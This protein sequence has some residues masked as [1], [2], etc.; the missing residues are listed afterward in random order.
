MLR[1]LAKKIPVFS[2]EMMM[3]DSYILPL[4]SHA[5]KLQKLK[6]IWH[7]FHWPHTVNILCT[8]FKKCYSY[9]R[10]GN[11]LRPLEL[12]SINTLGLLPHYLPSQWQLRLH[13]DNWSLL[14]YQIKRPCKQRSLQLLYEENSQAPELLRIAWT[15]FA[16]PRRAAVYEQG[17]PIIMFDLHLQTRNQNH[18]SPAYKRRSGRAH[19]RNGCTNETLYGLHATPQKNWNIDVHTCSYPHHA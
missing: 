1:G 15:N 2:L 16:W 10:G 12:V 3:Y 4:A 7:Q 19:P 6:K 14:K 9:S 18:I 13:D 8:A 17:L 5:R 11:S